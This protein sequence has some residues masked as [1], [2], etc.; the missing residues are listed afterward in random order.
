MAEFREVMKQW[1][2][3]CKACQNEAK[4]LG[5]GCVDLC[6][7]AH[8]DVCGDLEQ[9]KPIDIVRA[10]ITVM[11]WAEENPEPVYPTWREY[12]MELILPNSDSGDYSTFLLE[13]YIPDYIAEKLGVEPKEAK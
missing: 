9:V 11:L 3:M 10:E 5:L 7:L 12:L 6:K 13:Q 4:E 2:R 1:C 8:N